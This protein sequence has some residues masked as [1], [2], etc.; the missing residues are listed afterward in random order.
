[1]T[2]YTNSQFDRTD[3]AAGR[4]IDEAAVRS[5]YEEAPYPD[6]GADLKDLES[7]FRPVADELSR[8]KQ[9]RFLDVG[10]GTGHILVGVAKRHPDWDCC[11]IDLSQASLDVARQLSELHYAPVTLHRGSYLEPLPFDGGSFDVI[12]AMG[13]IHHTAD[14]AG[15]M[16]ALRDGMA[17]DGLML[18]HLYGWRCDAGKFDIKAVLDLLEPDISNHAVRFELYDG[19]MRH[20]QGRLLNRIATTTLADLY[21]GT[22][23]WLRNFGR[24][25]RK[26]SWSPPWTDQFTAPTPP[27]IDHFCHPCER[28]YEVPE[29]RELVESTGFRVVHNMRQGIEHR[30]LIPPDWGDRY[31]A[32]DDWDKRRMSELLADGGGSFAM[33][34]RKV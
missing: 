1:M 32:L 24:R 31:E 25:A 8:R 18:L 13:T 9:V 14:P 7:F 10:C 11:G 34:L 28:A 21:Y 19:L 16:R 26:E 12:S 17:D 33:W 3:G 20:R 5:M 15:A 30:Q 22:R 6:L 4:A 23:T 27:W 2:S 29:V